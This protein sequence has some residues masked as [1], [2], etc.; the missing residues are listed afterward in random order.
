M[1]IQEVLDRRHQTLGHVQRKE[2]ESIIQTEDQGKEREQEVDSTR[3]EEACP[4][5]A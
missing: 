5:D 4:V 2:I 3:A 1:E